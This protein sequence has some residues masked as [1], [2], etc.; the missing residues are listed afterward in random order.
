[1]RACATAAICFSRRAARTCV[2]LAGLSVLLAACSDNNNDHNGAS[3]A[4]FRSRQDAYLAHATSQVLRPG[5]V[6]HVLN[7]LERASRDSSFSVADGAVPADAWAPIFEKLFRLRDTSD[8][9][10]LYL[11]NLVYAYSGHPIAP[12]ALWDAADEAMLNFKY[13][14]T[15]PTPAREFDGAP[16]IDNMWYWTENHVLLFRVNEYLAGQRHPD[17]IFGVTGMTGAWHRERAHDAILEWLDERAR[18]GFTEW[19]SDVYYQKDITPLLTLVEWA[20]DEEL[21]NGA[22]MVL[23]LVLLDIALHLHRGN[24]GA[25]HG[26]SYVKDKASA[27]TQDAFNGTK[28]LFEDTALDFTSTSAPDASLLARARHYRM[29]DVIARI[30]GHDETMIDRERMNLPLD[31]VP[32]P[33][34]AVYPEAPPGLDWFDEANLPFW[35]SMGSQT[36]WMMV[37]LTLE[38]GERE[39][40]WQAQFAPYKPLRDIVWVEGD[41][42]ATLAAARPL[43]TQL[44][45]A[46]NVA[47][48]KE[49]NTYTYRTAHYMLSTAQDYRKGV[50]GAQTHISQATLDEQAMVFTQHPGY[51]PVAPGEP[52]PDDWNWQREDEPGPGYWTGNASEPRSAQYENVVIQLYAPQY[53]KLPSLGFSYIDETHAYFPQAH[54]DEV[55]QSGHWTFGRKGDAYVALYSLLPTEWRTGQPEVFENA[56]LPFDLV[57]QGSAENVWIIECGSAAQWESFADFQAMIA[58]APVT[59]AAVADRD[60]DG[61]PDGYSVVYDSPSVGTMEFDWHGP[62]VVQG[63]PVPIA[64][65]P[66]FDNPFVTTAFGATR[67]D[68]RYGEQSL[69]LDFAT[70]ER[71]V[72]D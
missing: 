70:A 1:M 60:G 47:L 41:M 24:F 8:F 54:F 21:A 23:D 30:A 62:L 71:R 9:D 38:I 64:D 14:Y 66:R 4:E 50:R 55:T 35:W 46:I 34:P 28:L 59:T 63:Q 43:L 61:F 65:Y 44:W 40:L 58:A 22:A 3:G 68:V 13:W 48:L 56:G 20:E 31:E 5:S 32:D 12:Q 6:L 51:L 2:L 18:Y 42:E 11:M 27:T 25:T 19:H 69:L 45:P 16:V 49:V 10:L 7:Y 39:N 57:A 53:G 37:P 29:P 72:S 33:D 17:R 26:R 52:V 67:Y 36:L 15:D